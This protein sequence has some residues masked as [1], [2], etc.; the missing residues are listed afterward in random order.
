MTET[1][2]QIPQELMQQ[3]HQATERFHAA[4]QE[5]EHWMD[6]SEFRHQERLSQAADHLR[7]AER[8]LESVEARIKQALSNSPTGS[9]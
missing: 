8:E 7:D 5:M 1:S 6:A 9:A 3:L 2:A 4:R